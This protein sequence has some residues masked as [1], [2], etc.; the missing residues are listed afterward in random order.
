MISVAL[1]LLSLK[2]QLSFLLMLLFRPHKI[3]VIASFI[4]FLN[5]LFIVYKK[6]KIQ[7]S[8]VSNSSRFSH[9]TP[10]LK[11]L[12]WLPIFYYVNFKICYI[13][14]LALSLHEPFYLST[15][16]THRIKYTFSHSTSFNL[17][18]LPYFNEKSNGFCTFS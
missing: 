4:A 10:T 14:H 3:F 16:L 1:I 6:C 17:L 8:I 2:L 18:I 15:L 11:S 5:I 13:K 7:A 9:I 12:H